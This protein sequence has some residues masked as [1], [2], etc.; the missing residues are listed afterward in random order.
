MNDYT[1]GSTLGSFNTEIWT[2]PAWKL[3][4]TNVIFCLCSIESLG[5]DK[6]STL[7]VASAKKN[8]PIL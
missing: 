8:E 5:L 2:L 6:N 4:H 7:I 1:F 3:S